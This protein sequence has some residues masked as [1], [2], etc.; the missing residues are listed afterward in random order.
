MASE[1]TIDCECDDV[2]ERKDDTIAHEY[3]GSFDARQT[4]PG[5]T[6]DMAFDR[7]VW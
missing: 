4:P 7:R 2:Y 6:D 1:E 3:D 5:D